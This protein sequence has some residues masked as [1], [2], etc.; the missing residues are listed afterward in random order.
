VST[1]ESRS[2]VSQ[3]SSIIAKSMTDLAGFQTDST[4]A[5]R[6]DEPGISDFTF[7]NP[8]EM[9]LASLVNALQAWSTPLN[10]D[11]FAYKASEQESREVA[12]AGLRDRTGVPFKPEDLA[13]TNGGIAALMIGIRTVIDPGDEV[14][15]SQPAWFLYDAMIVD[16]GATPVRVDIDPATFDL[17]LA[18]IEAAITPRTRVFIVNSPHN[19]TG[20]VVP[21][22]T[23]AKLAAIL[24]DAS[25]RNGR[26]I[27]LLS[28]EPYAKLVFGNGRAPSPAEHY[29][30]TL[31][32][33]SYGKQHLAPGQRIG[34]LAVSP[35]S[36][37]RKE[38]SLAAFVTQIATGWSFPNALMQHALADL[39]EVSI[40]LHHLR[41]KRDR[42]TNALRTMGYNVHLPEGTFYLFPQA[43]IADDR[44][45]SELLARHD[46]F[47][48][49]GAF[50]GTPGY[51]R[52]SLTAS[53][54]MIERSLPIFADAYHE[55]TA[56]ELGVAAG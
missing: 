42:M 51:F 18:A 48:M 10:K 40:D 33:Y 22:A 45:F 28:D 20:K 16:A 44:A 8:H 53:E 54:E 37:A 56:R 32:A 14:L 2:P 30:E 17:D 55:A 3:R 36:A 26:T 29:A 31:V 9:P 19:P 1:P 27:Y 46:V 41:R 5:R 38:I 52:I 50:F 49:P 11:W 7:G 34:F 43:P 25:A 39:E 13:M 12:A 24:E 21:S 47:V 35:R 23:L 6:R 15:Y 4:W